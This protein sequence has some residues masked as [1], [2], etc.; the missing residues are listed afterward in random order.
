MIWEVGEG[1]RWRAGPAGAMA[2]DAFRMLAGDCT[3]RFE[4]GG[5]SREERGDLLVLCKPDH[6]VLVHDRD[7]YRPVAWL[8]RAE[9]V[10]ERADPPGL[11]AVADDRRLRVTCHAVT[12]DERVPASPAGTPVEDCP[13]CQGTLIRSPGAV[14]C[15]G[16]DA[17]YR[18]P[19]D[20]ALT[21]GQCP[22]CGLPEMRVER[23]APFVL[24]VDRGCSSID[25]AVA[26]RFDGTWNCPA[27]NG[28][29]RIIRRDGLLAGC[30]NYPACEVAFAFPTGV[31]S[32]S[33]DC[34]LPAFAT[35]GGTRC[36]DATCPGPA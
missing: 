36:L 4:N 16:C 25:A 7:G 35:G 3:V 18:I 27:C 8:T 28:A 30:E 34:G 19:R 32:G 26:E 24:C 22:D 15:L 10:A 21:G 29:L 33:C 6:T 5:D 12:T 31:V 20:A 1:L 9:A 13:A 17:A 14:T 11:E 2:T 23:G